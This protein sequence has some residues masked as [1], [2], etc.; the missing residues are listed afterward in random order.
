VMLCILNSAVVSKMA[1]DRSVATSLPPAFSFFHV[2]HSGLNTYLSSCTT[3]T[4]SS[5]TS[6]LWSVQVTLSSSYI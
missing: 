4:T 1:H 3:D 2:A 6:P 5:I